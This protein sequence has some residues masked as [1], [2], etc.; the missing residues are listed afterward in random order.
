MYIYGILLLLL[1][2][3]FLNIFKVFQ[4]TN[5]VKKVIKL[6]TPLII[7]IFI[8]SVLDLFYHGKLDL[9]GMMPYIEFVCS[10]IIFA[11][12]N[13]YKWINCKLRHIKIIAVMIMTADIGV[14][15]YSI[16][17]G[18]SFG[19]FRA[20]ISGL[21]LNRMP[22]LFFAGIACFILIDKGTKSIYRIVGL[23]TILITLYRSAYLA[24]MAVMIYYILMHIKTLNLS[25]ILKHLIITIM[26]LA[27]GMIILDSFLLKDFKLL[28]TLFERL[29]S[30]FL[31]E[32]DVYGEASKSQ[33]LEQIIP[34]LSSII[35]NPILGGGFGLVL[36]DEPIYNYFNYILISLAILGLPVLGALIIP[37]H[38]LVKE[39]FTY[40]K[41]K[42][43]SSDLF[44][45]S[46]AVYFFILI[47]LFPYMT[48]FPIGSIFALAIC[49][50]SW[51]KLTVD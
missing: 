27:I 2:V 6:L 35:E 15:A 38:I 14:W 50:Y 16:Y 46:M 39:I 9:V 29:I 26:G 4:T 40:K 25:V 44:V 5:V 33:R 47:N 48:Y 28:E 11:C 12:I 36:S 30:T 49:Y 7:L 45:N 17:S 22:D 21:E 8:R 51:G 23:T 43:S 18:T 41:S 10:S 19:V 42:N 20:N 34:L 24:S 3:I 32:S 13:V 37:L 31:P 1:I